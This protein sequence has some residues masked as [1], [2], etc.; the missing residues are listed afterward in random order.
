MGSPKARMGTIRAMVAALFTA[1]MT[2]IPA[3]IKPRNM[4]PESPMKMRAGLKL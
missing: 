1:P 2:E 4:L 3:S